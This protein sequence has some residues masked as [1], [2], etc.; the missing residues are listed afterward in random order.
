M[1]LEAKGIKIEDLTQIGLSLMYNPESKKLRFIL[2][3]EVSQYKDFEHI[4]QTLT[5][6]KV[7]A[8]NGSWIYKTSIECPHCQNKFSTYQVGTT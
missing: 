5:E 3:D 4:K 1:E 6:E 2:S 8:E 7:R